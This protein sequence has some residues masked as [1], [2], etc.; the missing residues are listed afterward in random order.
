MCTP[1]S[2]R[3]RSAS[4]APTPNKC[5][6]KG[7]TISNKVRFL[8]LSDT[9]ECEMPSTMPECDV[10][11]HCGD[12][13]EDGSPESI[14]EALLALGKIK[15]ELRLIIAGNLEI[16][17]DKKYHC[18][19]GGAAEVVE[20]AQDLV[21]K[22]L[23]SKASECGITFLEE[24]THTFTLS[25]GVTF[26]IYTSPF[27]PAYGASGFQYPTNEDR[28]NPAK[29]T[30]AWAQNVGTETSTIPDNVDI[31]M[32][33]G[34][35][36]YILDSTSNGHSA[37]CEHLRRAI[38]RVKPKLHCF[39]H[40][41]AGYGAQRLEY[42]NATKKNDA[43]TIIPLAKEW[44]GKNQ[45]KKKGFANL[46]P[47]SLDDFRASAQ[48]LCV[49]AAMEGEKG[50]LENAPWVVDLDL[51]PPTRRPTLAKMQML[52]G[53][54]AASA[55][56]FNAPNA[57]GYLHLRRIHTTIPS[58]PSQNHTITNMTPS[59][60]LVLY[61]PSLSSSLTPSP[62]PSSLIPSRLFSHQTGTAIATELLYR[63]L[64]DIINRFLASFQRLASKGMEE[65]SS[66]LER[67]MQERRERIAAGRDGV[68][69]GSNIVEE[70]GKLAQQ[71]GF[72]MCPMGGQTGAK[73]QP[74]W[75]R[76]VLVGIEEGRL[77]ERDFWTNSW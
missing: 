8:V 43:D 21:S 30:P 70:V 50:V 62:S 1:T 73:M 19:E 77:H 48:T 35:P 24:G 61:R 49:N 7:P 44:V 26:R 32:T 51:I 13:T 31:V 23:T 36:K 67:R 64:F 58:Q 41:H 76:S 57:S 2:K 63:I 69:D 33:H 9:H 34:P 17:L 68:V 52:I 75:V 45:A 5:H 54:S 22:E 11:L 74:P 46:P 59:S 71:S 38:E 15:A 4:P 72:V 55:T 40:V 25:S 18:A 3:S 28:C 20:K 27:T 29:I 53:A 6:H 14:S 39:G 37:G 66:W 16:S 47:G 60:S 10:L 56:D 12:I 42:A 65:A